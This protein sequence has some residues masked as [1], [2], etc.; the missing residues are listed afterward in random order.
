MDASSG[1]IC[2]SELKTQRKY[3]QKYKENEKSRPSATIGMNNNRIVFG[4]SPRPPPSVATEFCTVENF[5]AFVETFQSTAFRMN[6]R[7]PSSL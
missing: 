4:S 7:S 1:N 3:R 6:A 2:G 5:S